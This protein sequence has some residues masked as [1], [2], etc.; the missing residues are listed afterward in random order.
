MTNRREFLQASAAASALGGL[1]GSVTMTPAQGSTPEFPYGLHKAVV[2]AD[3]SESRLFGDAIS[4]R[5]M[6]VH[7]FGR[8]DITDFWYSELDPVWKRQPAPIAGLTRHGPLF[9][10]ETL[11]AER[12]MRVALRCEHTAQSPGNGFVQTVSHRLVGPQAAVERIADRL[13]RGSAWPLAVIDGMARCADARAPLVEQV[14]TSQ[15]TFSFE[16]PL[17]SWVIVPR[18]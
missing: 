6:G 12:R 3:L 15:G 7:S 9:V 17:Y 2:D 1:L 14:I 10:L 4:R 16:D 8:G 11:A 5:G 13:R 18:A